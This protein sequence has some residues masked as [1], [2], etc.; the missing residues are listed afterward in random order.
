MWCECGRTRVVL[1]S[2]RLVT[3]WMFCRDVKRPGWT[4]NM[5]AGRRV[6]LCLQRRW[7]VS[8]STEELSASSSPRGES[9][10]QSDNWGI[11]KLRV[12]GDIDKCGTEGLVPDGEDG[13]QRENRSTSTCSSTLHRPLVFSI[14]GFSIFSLL[15][16]FCHTH[17]SSPPS[18]LSC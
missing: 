7:T 5:S 13:C 18:V 17:L 15:F 16:T 6:V 9:D 11:D 3:I 14:L 12:S 1:M 4:H 10:I 8:E 2:I